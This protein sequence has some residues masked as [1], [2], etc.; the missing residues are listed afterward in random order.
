MKMRATKRHMR[1]ARIKRASSRQGQGLAGLGTYRI[2]GSLDVKRR[3]QQKRL[4]RR[5]HAARSGETRSDSLLG[6]PD[7]NWTQQWL[8]RG[9]FAP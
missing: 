9:S 6:Q 4:L 5:P 3:R 1:N 7:M 8:R 2:P